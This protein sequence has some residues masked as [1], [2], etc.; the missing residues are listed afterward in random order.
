MAVSFGP[1]KVFV[2]V[3]QQENETVEQCGF[4]R[5]QCLSWFEKYSLL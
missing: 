5:T 3:Q 2:K 1:I 4:A